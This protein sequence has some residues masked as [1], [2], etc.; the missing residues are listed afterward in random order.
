MLLDYVD[1]P[2]EGCVVEAPHLPVSHRT[3]VRRES[4]VADD[5]SDRFET[6]THGLEHL[7]HEGQPDST[8][9]DMKK[10][11]AHAG[12]RFL[13]DLAGELFEGDPAAPGVE[14]LGIEATRG[15]N[16]EERGNEVD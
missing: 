11:H 13:A 4:K 6:V 12:I 7:A 5:T 3:A 16:T 2:V 8:I 15:E 1:E 10:L 14:R 9:R